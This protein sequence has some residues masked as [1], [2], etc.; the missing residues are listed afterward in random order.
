MSV[1]FENP[2]LN[3]LQTVTAACPAGKRVMGGGY[4]LSNWP[5]NGG[6]L[7]FTTPNNGPLANG[8]GWT[9]TITANL[10]V[11]SMTINVTAIC[12]AV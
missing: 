11:S 3:S 7:V 9:L 12:A 8:T 6:G 5:G 2:G 10:F 4:H 1:P